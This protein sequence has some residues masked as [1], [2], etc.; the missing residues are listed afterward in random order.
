MKISWTKG[1]EKERV[2]D[3]RADFKSSI[4]LRKR[5]IEILEDRIESARN[6][7]RSEDK[8]DSPNWPYIQAG[9]IERERAYLDIISLLKEENLD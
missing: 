9:L 8:Y 7:S 5:L 2:K 1:V 3:I 6:S 4:I